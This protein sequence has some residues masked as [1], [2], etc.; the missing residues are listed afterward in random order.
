MQWEIMENNGTRLEKSGNL[1]FLS[2]G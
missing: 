2:H 1:P